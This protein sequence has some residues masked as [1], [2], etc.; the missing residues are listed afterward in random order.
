VVQVLTAVLEH[1]LTGTDSGPV[2]VEGREEGGQALFSA[3]L[4]AQG[5]DAGAEPERPT[6]EQKALAIRLLIAEHL[7]ARLGGSWE[8]H[9]GRFCVRLPCGVGGQ[10]KSSS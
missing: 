9:A 6:R 5:E 3:A 2:F 7:L 8:R 4:G 10:G 1:L